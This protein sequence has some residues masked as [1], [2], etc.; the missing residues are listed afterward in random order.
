VELS[1]LIFVA[2][3]LVWAVVLLPK[4]LRQH[5]EVAQT[6]SVD[7]V[8]DSMR[9]LARRE[10]VSEREARLVRTPPP[11]PSTPPTTAA[12][13]E[14]VVTSSTPFVARPRTPMTK[15]RVRARIAAQR[16]AAAAAAGRRRLILLFLVVGGAGVGVAAGLGQLP[17]WT[18]AI[19]VV[20]TLG[21]LALAR[22]LVRK[23]H[24]RW[25]AELLELKVL[26]STAPPVPAA[27]A[28]VVPTES[29]DTAVVSG[30]DDTSSFP[31]GLLDDVT[32]TTDAG[33][34]WDPLP[35]TL[36]TYVSKPRASRSVRTI[37]LQAPGVSSSGH[38][39]ASSALVAD[40]ATSSPPDDLPQRAVGS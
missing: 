10:V 34:L 4:A 23:E 39:A 21:F 30:L 12:S 14:P 27:V 33:S 36:P 17:L 37:D 25:D 8:S 20:V 18:I 15:D 19:P 38:D 26:A 9:V 11:S 16:K 13:V 3:A 32:P 28:P 1:G 2:L 40:A 7:R 35:V 29:V 24:A 5:D 6:R 31:L 22:V